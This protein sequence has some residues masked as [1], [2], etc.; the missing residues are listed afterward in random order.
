MS[1]TY[2]RVVGGTGRDRDVTHHVDP[3][4]LERSAD[5]RLEAAAGRGVGP[6]QHRLR[7]L[8]VRESD[9]VGLVGTDD[10]GGERVVEGGVG[11]RA[12]R[13][14]PDARNPGLQHLLDPGRVVVREVVDRRD[15]AFVDHLAG[16]VD[17]AVRIALGV[18]DDGLHLGAVRT[19]AAALV[20][21]R[22]RRL[23]RLALVGVGAR[24]AT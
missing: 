4:R 14:E 16:A 8:A 11:F 7:L 6:H 23:E 10:P 20:E 18:A 9:C 22:D 17:F 12:G 15:D 19:E 1:A 2:G 13:T 24:S 5:E 21:R 3:G